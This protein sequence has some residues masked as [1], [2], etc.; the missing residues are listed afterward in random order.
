MDTVK[1]LEAPF[2]TFMLEETYRFFFLRLVVFVDMWLDKEFFYFSIKL[3]YVYHLVVFSHCD[4]FLLLT[5]INVYLLTTIPLEQ[6]NRDVLLVLLQASFYACIYVI[7]RPGLVMMVLGKKRKNLF[8]FSSFSLF[9][10]RIWLMRYLTT[11]SYLPLL[12]L[13]GRILFARK[14]YTRR[15]VIRRRERTRQDNYV[16]YWNKWSC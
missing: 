9:F 8:F 10:D 7:K 4:P 2:C 14:M 15:I 16:H 12:F 6:E 11:T 5:W 3:A 13:V 1:K